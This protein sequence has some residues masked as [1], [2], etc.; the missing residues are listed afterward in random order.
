MNF[1]LFVLLFVTLPYWLPVVGLFFI[2]IGLLWVICYPIACTVH[3]LY[4][5]A[6][7]GKWV[8][9]QLLYPRK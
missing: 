1:A 7:Y 4:I 2:S 6:V 5:R 3:M 9:W 8:H